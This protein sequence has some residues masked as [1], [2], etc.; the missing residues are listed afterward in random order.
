[1]PAA[2]ARVSCDSF[3]S[4]VLALQR[5]IGNRATARLLQR[6]PPPDPIANWLPNAQ[7]QQQ[8]IATERARAVSR[9]ATGAELGRRALAAYRRLQMVGEDHPVVA[10]N[11]ET[12]GPPPTENPFAAAQHDRHVELHLQAQVAIAGSLA[13][14]GASAG[15]QPVIQVVWQFHDNHHW[16]PEFSI[17]LQ[18]NAAVAADFAR[19]TS[20]SSGWQ[21]NLQLAIASAAYH[22]ANR[23]RVQEQLFIGVSA[24]H[25]YDVPAGD[26]QSATHPFVLGQVGVQHSFLLADWFQVFIQ[27][28]VGGGVTSGQGGLGGPLAPFVQGGITVGGTFDWQIGGDR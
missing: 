12:T 10:V 4:G 24:G 7:A 11:L 21:A 1:M 3:S 20:A 22:D 18:G 19:N 27:G 13:N 16:G 14:T 28:T 6:D 2:D 25:N 23:N 26:L 15:V 5:Q 17:G 9:A 8:F